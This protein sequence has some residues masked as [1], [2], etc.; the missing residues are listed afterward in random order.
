[1]R[2]RCALKR[3]LAPQF[4]SVC[5]TNGANDTSHLVI[6]GISHEKF[7]FLL[8]TTLSDVELLEYGLHANCLGGRETTLVHGTAL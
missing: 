6:H 7:R 1:M 4:A 8:I 5:P 2:H 3:V